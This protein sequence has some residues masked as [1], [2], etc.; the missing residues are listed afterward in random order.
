MSI[1]PNHVICPYSYPFPESDE[2]LP[3]VPFDSLAIF[4]HL[5]ED[6]NY[7]G[8]NCVG[9]SGSHLAQKTYMTPFRILYALKTDNTDIPYPSHKTSADLGKNGRRPMHADRVSPFLI[10][11]TNIKIFRLGS[12]RSA[13]TRAIFNPSTARFIAGM[14]ALSIFIS[15]SSMKRLQPSIYRFF[16]NNFK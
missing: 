4:N 2:T 9:V 10:I 16:C 1:S 11:A 5:M 7:F 13:P 14:V 6:S 12:H 8:E 3:A 15:I